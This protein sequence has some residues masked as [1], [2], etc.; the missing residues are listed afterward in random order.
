MRALLLAAHLGLGVAFLMFEAVQH[1]HLMEQACDNLDSQALGLAAPALMAERSAAITMAAVWVLGA[2]SHAC[3]LQ[4]EA[5]IWV[6]P[7]AAEVLGGA[8][9]T[10]HGSLSTGCSLEL[11]EALC[12]VA[13]DSLSD[14]LLRE[15]LHG[16]GVAVLCGSTVLRPSTP[17][18]CEGSN[19]PQVQMPVSIQQLAHKDLGELK[20]N[21]RGD[22]RSF[23][24]S[25]V[26]ASEA[27]S[28]RER[29]P[30]SSS[31]SRPVLASASRRPGAEC[32]EFEIGEAEQATSHFRPAP[33][34]RRPS[35]E[36]SGLGERRGVP[37][38]VIDDVTLE[39]VS[40]PCQY[41]YDDATWDGQGWEKPPQPGLNGE[42]AEK[43]RRVSRPPRR[44][45]PE[46]RSN[47]AALP[48]GAGVGSLGASELDE[49]PSDNSGDNLLEFGAVGIRRST[50]SARSLSLKAA[51]PTV[52]A[53]PQPSRP[54]TSAQNRPARSGS[55]A[56]RASRANKTPPNRTADPR[57]SLGSIAS[58]S[59]SGRSPGRNLLLGSLYGDFAMP[60]NDDFPSGL[61]EVDL[62]DNPSWNNVNAF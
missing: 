43:S 26:R 44:S 52:R 50:T 4:C 28:R 40:R 6:S 5:C 35:S 21:L 3:L 54:S 30:A 29:E 34:P 12:G 46:R 15:F 39:A 37:P 48:A 31:S 10:H 13:G 57:A 32:V 53:A 8:L 56:E 49:Q 38:P 24:A 2:L 23:D 27:L 60:Q 51:P 1:P 59:S 61:Q 18:A 55:R 11:A 19:L 22:I 7:K 16:F 33:R 42:V 47:S 58:S 14:A 25:E 9:E 20:V 45:L 17:A 62:H 41:D 36:N